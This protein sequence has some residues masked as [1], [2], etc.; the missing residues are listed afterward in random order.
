MRMEMAAQDQIIS[1]LKEH[2]LI[3]EKAQKECTPELQQRSPSTALLYTTL[4]L[5]GHIDNAVSH[6]AVIVLYKREF[7]LLDS[8]VDNAVIS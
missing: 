5:Y 7:W 8:F 2:L 3:S 4:L 1:I 6:N